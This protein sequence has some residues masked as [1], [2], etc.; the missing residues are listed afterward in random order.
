MVIKSVINHYQIFVH[1]RKYIFFVHVKEN[2]RLFK[3]KE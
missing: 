1:I 2:Q 3:M